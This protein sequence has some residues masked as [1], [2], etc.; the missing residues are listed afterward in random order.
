MSDIYVFSYVE[1]QP[2]ADVARKLVEYRNKTAPD[3]IRFNEGFPAVLNG[4]GKIKVMAP[5]LLK[6]AKAGL[7]TFVITDLDQN[8][9]APGMIRD[10]FT[11]PHAAP[12][13]LPAE[14]VFRVAIREVEAW[15]MAD[16]DALADFTGISR[17]NFTT[18]PDAL[19]DPKQYLLNVIRRKKNRRWHKDMLPG[20]N[21]HVGP[22]Y[23][24]KLSEFVS[25]FW[26]PERAKCNSPSLSAAMEALDRLQS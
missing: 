17:S 5:R 18:Q 15:L 11:L 26:S 23:N 1:D 10:W 25:N 2:S 4:F 24:A 9:C 6:M 3:P 13:Q 12:V 22:S 21:A 19:P 16:L 7:H 14:V 8:E 20:R